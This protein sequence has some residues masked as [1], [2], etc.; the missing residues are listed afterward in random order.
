MKPIVITTSCH[1]CG[2]RVEQAMHVMLCDGCLD[3]RLT[4]LER[5]PA[6]VLGAAAFAALERRVPI[7]A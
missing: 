7:A 1:R 2:R 4:E 5:R 6:R 3:T